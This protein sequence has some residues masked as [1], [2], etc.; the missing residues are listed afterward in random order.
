MDVSD[1]SGKVAVVT[2]AA[3]GIG[4]ATALALAQRGAN[5]AICDVDEPA[6]K[7]TASEIEQLGRRVLAVVVDVANP[8]QMSAY[9]ERCEAELAR[10]DLLVNNAGIGVGGAFVDVP[11]SE[12]DS[13]IDINL[14][15][16]VHGC[17]FFVPRMIAAGSGGHIVNIASMA[18][19][20]ATP[21]MTAYAT[22][23]FGVIGFSEALAG[24]L[25]EHGIGVTA[26]CPG[27]INTPIVHS[28]RLYGPD[29][30][31]ENRQR[32]VEMFARRNYGPERVAT[33]ILKAVRRNRLVAPV[34]P[35]AWAG[36]WLKRLL[37]GAVTALGRA[38][39]RRGNRSR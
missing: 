37:P 29:A 11:L 33:A 14:K 38:M 25:A 20:V 7:E 12:W 26:V 15:G 21:G 30:T 6:L 19:Y 39:S 17:Y 18:G 22:T 24:D 23:K 36:Y 32:G 8:D 16:V 10:I 4:R 2:G 34:S 3:S 5:L 13:I 35:E 27:V 9:A 1:L 31:P 28:S